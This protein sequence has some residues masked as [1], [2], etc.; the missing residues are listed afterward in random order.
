MTSL[1][2]VKSDRSSAA[3]APD[4][5]TFAPP[6]FVTARL[7]TPLVLVALAITSGAACRREEKAPTP[8]ATTAARAH[9]AA[10]DAPAVTRPAVLPPLP[11]QHE[12]LADPR[13][14]QPFASALGLPPI[15]DV[16]QLT[17]ER[18]EHVYRAL[19]NIRNRPDDGDAYGALGEVYEALNLRPYALDLYQRAERMKPGNFEWPYQQGRLDKAY[20]SD[21]SAAAALQRAVALDPKYAPA[22]YYLGEVFLSLGRVADAEAAFRTYAELEPDNARSFIGLAL[23]AQAR[24]DWPGMRAILERALRETKPTKPVH[25]LLGLALHKLGHTAEA[26]AELAR[27]ES[28][29]YPGEFHDRLE[30]RVLQ[31]RG[32]QFVLDHNYDIR[33]DRGDFE[34]AAEQAR[35]MIEVNRGKELE[36]NGWGRLAEAL[37]RAGRLD[38]AHAAIETCLRLSPEPAGGA[39]AT[40]DL[41]RARVTAALLAIDTGQ[42][43]DALRYAER[44]TRLDP[45]ND[46]ASYARGLARG[47]IA[48]MDDMARA[49]LGITT[50]PRD[51]LD[52]AVEDFTRAARAKPDQP[53]YLRLLGEAL[54]HTERY[55]EAVE[56]LERAQRIAPDDPIVPALLKAAR[57]ELARSTPTTTRTANPPLAPTTAPA[58]AT[59]PAASP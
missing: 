16:T 31:L 8:D 20:G 34:G 35:K 10:H 23:V 40:P 9:D 59:G 7:R 57:E 39:F 25:K 1:R 29:T 53:L 42:F 45:Q 43:A 46:Q 11:L 50:S 55:A 6:G 52:G 33:M 56:Q 3:C 49:Q 18:A 15:P 2:R 14:A 37:R 4:G 5:P 36:A 13:S 38:E 19:E 21:E 58:A 28:V 30:A 41:A 26:E 47:L 27:A 22:Q 17:K 24:E 48:S 51:L 32:T 12:F 54:L 44:A